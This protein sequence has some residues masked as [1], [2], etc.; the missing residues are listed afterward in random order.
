MQRIPVSVECSLDAASLEKQSLEWSQLADIALDRRSAE[1]GVRVTVPR[2]LLSEV[3]E[4]VARERECWG[5]W[6]K[7][8]V[9]TLGA[10]I[11]I[12]LTTANE[13]GVAFLRSFQTP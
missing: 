4:L 2:S 12:S 6:M 3:E 9:A 1:A 7:I 13:D 11:E 10:V 8:D 5:S